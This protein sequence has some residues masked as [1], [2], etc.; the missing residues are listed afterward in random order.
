MAE[1]SHKVVVFVPHDIALSCKADAAALSMNLSEY[2]AA[3]IRERF[4]LL[5]LNAPVRAKETAQ[6]PGIAR[7]SLVG[8]AAGRG[9]GDPSVRDMEAEGYAA[10]AERTARALARAR[11]VP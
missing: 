3:V 6:S 11:G 8:G 7:S 1:K 4:G 5:K 10:L 9:A 2:V